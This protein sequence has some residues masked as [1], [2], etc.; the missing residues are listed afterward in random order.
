[1][2]SDFHSVTPICPQLNCLRLVFYVHFSERGSFEIQPS[3]GSG[4]GRIVGVLCFRVREP[5]E[6]FR[7]EGLSSTVCSREMSGP[8]RGR[9]AW[10]MGGGQGGHWVEW[11][12]PEPVNGASFGKRVLR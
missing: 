8:P 9:G 12:P 10:E 11:C 2:T 6:G 4:G 3:P 7:Q 5:W 1:M